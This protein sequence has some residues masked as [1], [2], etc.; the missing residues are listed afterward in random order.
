MFGI[1]KNK[2]RLLALIMFVI[3]N[4]VVYRYNDYYVK[5]YRSL[6]VDRSNVS[7]VEYGTANYN[8]KE[9]VSEPEGSTIKVKKDVDTSVVGVQTVVLEIKKDDVSKLVEVPVEVKDTVYPEVEIE[10]ESLTVNTGE[11]ID[12]LS[13]IKSVSD[14]VDGDIE[15]SEENE[16]NCYKIESDYNPNVAGVYS[17]KVIAI[18][19]TGNKTEKQFNIK[20]INKEL[21][22]RVVD[23]AMG[24]VGYPYVYGTAGPSSFD[25]S[26]F[27]QFVYRQIGIG[28]SRSSGTQAYDGYAVSYA[29]AQPGDIISLGYGEGA[30]T[31]SALYIGNGKM[32][33][34]ANSSQGVIVSD[35]QSWVNGSDVHIVTVRRIV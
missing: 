20:V 7:V 1:I 34:A 19:K 2:T 12:L 33:H 11:E 30:V 27:V 31:H 24:Y 13:N 25:C 21:S 16:E 28:L 4:I 32:V 35:V 22:K 23:I 8:I 6:D 18:D 15:Y 10:N 17:A 14:K 5:T 9:Y 29:E 26:G 3:L